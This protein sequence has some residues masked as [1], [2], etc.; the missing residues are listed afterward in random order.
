MQHAICAH[1]L[2]AM[3]FIASVAALL[4]NGGC[5]KTVQWQEEVKLNDGR[6]IVVTQKRRCEGGNYT[7]NKD[8]TCIARESWLTFRL[9]EFSGHE[10]EWHE[11]LKPMTINV[12]DGHLYLVG[13]P[14]TSLEFR[15][16]G[17]P[18]P[19]YLGFRW[20]KNDWIRIEFT[21]IPK[22]I[23]ETNMLIE[24]IPRNRTHL[25]RLTVKDSELENGNPM[26]PPYFRRID[27]GFRI[28]IN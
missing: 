17:M 27:P 2:K 28:S 10:I 9:P 5:A 22:S 23:Y 21:Q 16:Y 18:S 1:G 11:N 26:Y 4:L 7:A 19:P 24:N 20:D 25:L 6:I 12:N 3:L 15:K 13:L 14:P 8:A